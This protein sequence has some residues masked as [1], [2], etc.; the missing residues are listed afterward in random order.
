MY[1]EIK[2]DK[3]FLIKIIFL[4]I[5]LI[6]IIVVFIL[7]SIINDKKIQ[8]LY[9]QENKL[10]SKTM[11]L[12]SKNP[13]DLPQ[14]IGDSVE[15]SLKTLIKYGYVDNIYD[16]DNKKCDESSYVKVIKIDEDEYEYE[17]YL[18]C[19]KYSTEK[20][21]NKWTSWSDKDIPIESD[22]TQIEK[23]ILYSSRE[24]TEN[25]NDW[26]EWQ[27]ITKK[28]ED[29]A[30]EYEYQNLY[31]YRD[32]KWKWYNENG[33]NYAEGYYTSSP[34][35]GYI[36]DETE[37]GWTKWTILKNGSITASSIKEVQYRNKDKKV[38]T[39]K[40]YNYDYVSSKYSIR[41]KWDGKAS[42]WIYKY[43]SA[44]ANGYSYNYNTDTTAALSIRTRTV[45]GGDWTTLTS[46]SITSSQNVEVRFRDKKYRY[47]RYKYSC[48][49]CM[50]DY[51]PRKNAYYSAYYS[52]PT[53]SQCVNICVSVWGNDYSIY[54]DCNYVSGSMEAKYGDYDRHLNNGS[55]I[56][57]NGYGRKSWT[58]DGAGK[59]YDYETYNGTL[60]YDKNR[61][62]IQYRELNNYSNYTNWISKTSGIYNV[63][64]VQDI[65][66]KEKLYK[67]YYLDWNYWSASKNSGTFTVNDTTQVQY[68][69][70]AYKY[71]KEGPG[72]TAEF[73]SEEPV[74]YPVKLDDQFIQTDWSNWNTTK[75]E[76]K[77]Y[78]T[79]NEKLQMRQRIASGNV[80]ENL[81]RIELE[82]KFGKTLEELENN[83]MI[84]ISKKVFYR[85]RTRITE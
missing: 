29:K 80:I 44:G 1:E 53:S 41:A 42:D 21:W 7:F 55:S 22:N 23:K 84:S 3:K 57:S 48:E 38:M 47:S 74:G 11:E 75:P 83:P 73:Y 8:V 51:C 15:I 33:K 63:S 62:E 43:Y 58:I 10:K 46:G 64:N 28:D 13:E 4:G 14:N 27:D 9:S 17:P 32:T 67:Y 26:D 52:N 35:E 20:S 82:E 71:Y 56:I 65:A 18:I 60:S 54:D 37:E 66:Y 49:F 79:I 40:Y 50:A 24:V 76:E 45:T 16:N 39:S 69:E 72:T 5:F 25:L 70:K 36:K 12:M 59:Y 31:Q 30:F 34:G 78:R 2:T 77:E 68:R 81:T 6:V 85:Y 19:G 61:R